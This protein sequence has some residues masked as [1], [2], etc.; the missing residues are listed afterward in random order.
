MKGII[1]THLESMVDS[2]MGAHAWQRVV[3]ETEL[4]T[5]EG[6]FVGPRNYPDE[7]L[8]ALVATASRLSG[9][10][11][12][13]LVHAFGRFLFAPLA[14]AFPGFIRPEMTSKSF[15]MTVDRVIHIEVRKLHP[16]ALLPTIR[17]EDPAGDR[18]ILLYQSPRRL[19]QLAIGLI[20]GTA[21]HFHERV[22]CEH[23]RCMKQGSDHCRFE[24]TFE[25]DARDG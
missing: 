1:F 5:T 7:D 21:A 14:R 11:V 6:Y 3:A 8:F 12:D 16:D 24:C 18:L 19:C 20:E 25:V 22:T 23:T 9:T 10:P 13:E 17:Y 4:R 15:L 2:V